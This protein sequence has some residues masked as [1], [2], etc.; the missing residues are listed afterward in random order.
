MER[1]NFSI[2][3]ITIFC[4]LIFT[5]GWISDSF[6][7][8]FVLFRGSCSWTQFKTEQKQTN[9]QKDKNKKADND[10]KWLVH[11]GWFVRPC[12]LRNL[13]ALKESFYSVVKCRLQTAV[14]LQKKIL[15]SFAFNSD[16]ARTRNMIFTEAYTDNRSLISMNCDSSLPRARTPVQSGVRDIKETIV[17][18]T[19]KGELLNCAKRS[20]PRTFNPFFFSSS[21][22]FKIT[23]S[24]PPG[25]RRGY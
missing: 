12:F 9:K 21:A 4:W 22:F 15:T 3:Q 7:F 25:S 8:R 13:T 1:S 5:N 14:T 23:I 24:I 17:K 2:R 19:A 16:V 6:Y 18:Q 10:A 20:C 11:T